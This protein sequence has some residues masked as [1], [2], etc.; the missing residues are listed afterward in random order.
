MEIKKWKSIILISLSGM[1]IC[2]VIGF[3]AAGTNTVIPGRLAFQFTF[4]GLFGSLLYA[5][6]KNATTRD[7]IF[8]SILFIVFDVIVLG[9][10][11]VSKFIVHGVNGIL[12]AGAIFLYVK[13]LEQ[14]SDRFFSSNMFS[15]SGITAFAFLFAV[16]VLSVFPKYKFEYSFLEGQTFFG[17]LI[18]FG[19][20]VGFQV[21]S[22]FLSKIQS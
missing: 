11:N 12:I 13:I 7:F 14:D 6:L 9:G 1:I 22:K 16:L 3:I 17:L 5:I 2:M 21:Y 15:I 4:Y 8:V 19:L 10:G 18:G 20:G